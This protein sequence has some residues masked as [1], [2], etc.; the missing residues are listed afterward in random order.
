MLELRLGRVLRRLSREAIDPLQTR[1][2]AITKPP[3]PVPVWGSWPELVVGVEAGFGTSEDLP[4]FAGA[5]GTGAG[6]GASAAES[7]QAW[8]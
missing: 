4:G 7:T 8:C 6:A 3:L 1:I 2:V 5:A